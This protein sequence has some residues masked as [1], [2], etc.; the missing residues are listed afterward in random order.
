VDRRQF[1]AST[2]L[3]AV[4]GAAALGLDAISP[5]PAE[6]A[7]ARSVV[8]TENPDA[9]QTRVTFRTSPLDRV[10][11]LTFDDGPTVAWTPL[12]LSMLASHQAKATF[13]LVGDRVLANPG[14]ARAAAAAGHEL[15]NHTWTHSDLTRHGSAFIADS[16]QRTHNVIEEVTGATPRLLRPPWGRIDSV[17]LAA[18]TRLHYDVILWSEHVTGSDATADVTRIQ[19][20]VTPGTIVLAHDGGREPNRHL[21]RAVDTLVA[22]LRRADYTFV[23]VSELLAAQ[24]QQR[25]VPRPR[26]HT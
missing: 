3:V 5:T 21:I 26:A 14:L 19:R 18:C 6:S 13:F 25:P 11:A 23:T 12:V 1:L 9:F 4:G 15:G 7:T 17:G 2:G 24:P 8:P 20:V 16:L 10:V 22:S